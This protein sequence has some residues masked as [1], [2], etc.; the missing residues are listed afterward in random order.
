MAETQQSMQTGGDKP[1]DD[2]TYDLVTII[3]E[4]SKGLEAYD[5]YAQDAQGNEGVSSLLEELRN[6]DTQAV[7]RLKTELQRLLENQ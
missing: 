4:K 7:S 6:Q 5:K 3:Y 2:L 1:L